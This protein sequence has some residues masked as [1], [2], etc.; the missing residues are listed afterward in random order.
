MT[1]RQYYPHGINVADSFK[2][3]LFKECGNVVY[4]MYEGVIMSAIEN[5]KITNPVKETSL[6]PLLIVKETKSI[7][8]YKALYCAKQADEVHI[9]R[10]FI[11]NTKGSKLH[12]LY[13]NKKIKTVAR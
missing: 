13:N 12:F 6:P 1:H 11:F 4:N 5:N 8:Y 2:K 10:L 7:N 3:I 9:E